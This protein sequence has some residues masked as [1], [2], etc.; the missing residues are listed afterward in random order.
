VGDKVLQ[1]VGVLLTDM[2]RKADYVARL[3][4]DEFV[5]F[6]DGALRKSD[7]E[8]IVSRFLTRVNQPIVI[9]AETQVRIGGSLGIAVLG[10]DASDEEALLRMA[11]TAMYR[12]KQAG[13]NRV[14]AEE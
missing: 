12:A 6:L 11:D 2:V 10:E 8:Q 3:G 4:G 5:V 13:R 14:Y 9:D 7:V 1:H